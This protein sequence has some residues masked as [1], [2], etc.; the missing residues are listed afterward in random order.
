MITVFLSI[1]LSLVLYGHETSYLI[2]RE[3]CILRVSENRVLRQIF[4]PKMEDLI[5]DW[6]KL[7][8][9]ELCD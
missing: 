3:E 8:I 9:E 7:P 4:A 6:R 2:L 1:I 5:G